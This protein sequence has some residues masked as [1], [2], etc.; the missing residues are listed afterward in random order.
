MKLGLLSRA[1]RC[2]LIAV[3]A[4]A[5]IGGAM[6]AE[7]SNKDQV[8]IVIPAFRSDDGIGLQVAYAMKARIQALLASEHR[9]SPGKRFGSAISYLV[10]KP[11]REDTFDAA[12]ALAELNGLQATLW[13]LTFT[14][15]DGIAVEP[16]LAIDPSP[17]DYR[18]GRPELWQLAVD[19]ENLTLGLPQYAIAFAPVTFSTEAVEKY[20]RVE[21]IPHC[22][23]AGGKCVYFS[24]YSAISRAY[25]FEGN[26]ATIHRGGN[27]YYVDFP[28]SELLKSEAIDY[29]AM[30]IAYYRGN[31]RQVVDIARTMT[32]KGSTVSVPARIDALLYAGASE[33]RIG[34]LDAAS[35]DFAAAAELNPIAQR[36]FRFRLM[37]EIMR[38]Q[39]GDSSAAALLALWTEYRSYYPA[40][41]ELDE[42]LDRL[43]STVWS[44]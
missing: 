11:M 5:S 8:G 44:R 28:S 7:E 35:A 3:L 33:A 37:G 19:G 29:A 1:F 40:T 27:D 42:A 18:A 24:D 38:W 20:G 39:A 32:G 25:G 6:S 10:P 31:F 15:T 43:A 13:G 9:L 4:L 36:T 21:G 26:R 17:N 22:P 2:V 41:D 34:L 12:I 30:I 23:V 16:H 14:L